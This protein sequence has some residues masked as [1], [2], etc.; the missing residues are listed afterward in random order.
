MHRLADDGRFAV[1]SPSAFLAHDS[2]GAAMAAL[3][4]I[5]A[6]LLRHARCVP[7]RR[8]GMGIRLDSGRTAA[9]RPFRLTRSL[10]ERPE[11]RGLSVRQSASS[12]APC[13][14]AATFPPAS[15]TPVARGSH[16]RQCV[17]CTLM[18]LF[19]VSAVD[20][21]VEDAAAGNASACGVV[22][23]MT[24]S[25]MSRS[26]GAL[27]VGC[28]SPCG[29]PSWLLLQQISLESVPTGHSF[30]PGGAILART[31]GSRPCAPG[32]MSP[33]RGGAPAPRVHGIS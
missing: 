24:A 33:R 21:A 32:R 15:I 1:V 5:A 23:L 11:D 31:S 10:G 14:A 13:R 20:P 22:S 8:A 4:C 2:A 30:R 3:A 7:Q 19:R 9:A 12:L 26:K 18:L 25:S 27:A 17:G 16:S 29:A 28:H 6:E